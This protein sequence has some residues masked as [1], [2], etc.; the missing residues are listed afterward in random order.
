MTTYW[1]IHVNLQPRDKAA[2]IA[3]STVQELNLCMNRVLIPSYLDDVKGE[4]FGL[5]D[6][7]PIRDDRKNV[8]TVLRTC[9][10]YYEEHSVN[11]LELK[12]IGE[13][14]NVALEDH[15]PLLYLNS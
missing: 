6:V 12:T 13:C 5:L 11:L 1:G 10:I 3:L 4:R 14:L 9:R 2:L 15:I 7:E 8:S